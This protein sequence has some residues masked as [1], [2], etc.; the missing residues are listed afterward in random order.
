MKR[1]TEKKWNNRRKLDFLFILPLICTESRNYVYAQQK[2]KL[3]M[4]EIK[5]GLFSMMA[6]SELF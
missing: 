5:R 1:A 4:T 2:E 3:Q 6:H